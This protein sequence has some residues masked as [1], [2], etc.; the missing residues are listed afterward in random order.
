MKSSPPWH[1]TESTYFGSQ[2]ICVWWVVSAAR[3]WAWL[4]AAGPVCTCCR[5]AGAWR[6]TGQGQPW[7]V[8]SSPP[9][10][11]GVG[12]GLCPRCRQ[13]LRREQRPRLGADINLAPTLGLKQV[14][15][16]AQIQGMGKAVDSHIFTKNVGRRGG[17]R[18]S[19]YPPK[20]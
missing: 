14:R 16:P 8:S 1:S 3:G 7:L 13:C 11:P 2:G 17:W 18:R 15:Q 9:C 19:V 5:L 20:G 10:S 6:L 12:P 4:M